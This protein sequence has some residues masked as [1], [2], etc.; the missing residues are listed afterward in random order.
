MIPQ[1][2]LDEIFSQLGSEL[3]LRCLREDG[4]SKPQYPYLTYKQLSNTP[5]GSFQ[6]ITEYIPVSGSV[7]SD[8][9]VR[10]NQKSFSVV[11]ISVLDKTLTDGLHDKLARTVRWF[12]TYDNI[13]SMQASGVTP[14][15]RGIQI[16]DRT[17]FNEN[18]YV[19]R[20]GFDLTFDYNSVWDQVTEAIETISLESQVGEEPPTEIIID[21]QE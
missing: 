16:Q 15:N 6:N 20:L 13:V 5:E 4:V 14:R 12:Q 8:V 2:I 10:K 11:S 18:F 7:P 3:N 21:T 9:T 1:T 19:G 17:F